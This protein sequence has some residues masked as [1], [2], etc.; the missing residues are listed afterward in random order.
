[1]YPN[2]NHLFLQDEI[3]LKTMKNSNDQKDFVNV[4]KLL[5]RSAQD[6]I[7][8]FEV[9]FR[10]TPSPAAGSGPWTPEVCINHSQSSIGCSLII[11]ICFYPFSHNFNNFLR[12]II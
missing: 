7:D 9:I 12:S 1:M 4:A 3:L 2:K 8:R 11:S 6:C 5:G 10:P